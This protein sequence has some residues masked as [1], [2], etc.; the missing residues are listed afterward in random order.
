MLKAGTPTCYVAVDQ[1]DGT[2]CYVQW[3]LGPAQ[4]PT[5]KKLGCFPLLKPDEALLENAYTPVSYRGMGIMAAAMALIAERAAEFGARYVLTFV[6]VDNIASLKGCERAGFTP[7]VVRWQQQYCFNLVRRLAF[8]D[9][10]A[11][12]PEQRREQPAPAG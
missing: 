2:P 8:K 7:F 11:D 10:P 6:G 12:V 4:N 3:L 1:R 9:L 5:I